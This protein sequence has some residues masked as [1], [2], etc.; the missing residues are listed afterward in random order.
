MADQAKNMGNPPTRLTREE[1]EKRADAF[2]QATEA[3]LRALGGRKETNVSFH[4]GNMPL[5]PISLGEKIRLSSPTLNLNEE[6]TQ[7]LRGAADAQALR[8]KHHDFD[9][10]A[11][12]RPADTIA[13]EVY[14]ALEQARVEAVGARHM[15]GVAAN[16]RHR[17]EQEIHAAGLDHM[18]DAAQLSPVVGLE[19]LAR[20]KLTGEPL[21]ESAR[22][23][24]EQWKQTLPQEALAALD[25]L[26]AD[27]DSQ[28]AYSRAARK[29]LAACALTDDDTLSDQ[30]EEDENSG[31]APDT[32][33]DESEQP[34]P[35]QEDENSGAAPDMSDAVSEPQLMAGSADAADNT[36]EVEQ[37][38]GSAEGTGDAAGPGNRKDIEAGQ[39]AKGYHAYT[40]SFDEEILAEDLCDPEELSR[41][42]HQLD[43]QLAT[44]H[45]VVSRLA[46]RLQRRLMA[47]QTRSWS[48]D[49]E[50][51]MLD[52]GRLS[53]I[54]V[55][56]RLS[57]SYKQEKDTEFRDTVV[58]LLIDNSGSMRG[59]PISVAASC[60][61]ILARTLERCGVKV[62][63]LGFTT[64][65]W[66]GGQSRELWVQNHKPE[67][68][69]RLNDLRHIVYK[70]ADT[71]WRRAR[72]NLGLMLREGLLKENIDGEALLWAWRRT[73]SRPEARKILMV[74]SDGAPVDDST[75][76]VN[77]ASYL[78]DH[79]REVISMI[80]NRSPVELTAIGIGHD[81]TRYYQRAVT[82]TD[83]EELGGTMLQSLS[84]LFDEKR[85]RKRG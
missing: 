41:L 58:T 28:K 48:F 27:Q 33:E 78:E 32:N 16:L 74:I 50:E 65:A 60:G 79:L 24:M 21:P 55:N 70:G 69:G 61:D 26:A 77:P 13:R 34:P 10:H 84:A 68:P 83:A 63:I 75:L 1:A 73:K 81:V 36:P 31:T 80:E 19:L 40:T 2:K 66:K 22:T 42:R 38:S 9:L 15:K 82:I 5:A 11:A 59:R 3:T 29:L 67:N 45:G 17:L 4:S 71:P 76:S 56:P 20:E 51:G 64:R 8:L 44:L 43:L 12:R 52:A 6:E 57:L 72:T 23:I 39:T 18:T 46:N 47:Q 85:M 49:L 14:D 62:E 7:R 30:E 25:T 35:E 54:V 53:R 37:E